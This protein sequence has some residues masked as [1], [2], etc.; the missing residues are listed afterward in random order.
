RSA[1]K[2]I[3]WARRAAN[4]DQSNLSK[5]LVVES[6]AQLSAGDPH[7]AELT[8]KRAANIA[9]NAGE[10]GLV[11]SA[12]A[13]LA[14]CQDHMGDRRSALTYAESALQLLPDTSDLIALRDHF[15]ISELSD[16]EQLKRY[17]ELAEDRSVHEQGRALYLGMA[18]RAAV[19]MQRLSEAVN[20]A[21]QALETDRRIFD[22]HNI[23]VARDLN[24][25]GTALVDAGRLDEAEPH[26]REA[27][28]I[29][30]SEIPDHVLS[31]QPRTHLSRLLT[32]RA[33]KSE[34]KPAPDLVLLE[35]A[36]TIVEPA[37]ARQREVAPNT[38]EYSS[39]LVALADSLAPSNGKRAIEL[40]EQAVEVDRATF[41]DSHIET[42]IDALKL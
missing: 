17:R 31:V 3:A 21:T 23:Y 33:W 30:E 38:A 4:D 11:A 2:Q 7:G 40:L 15:A 34:D 9:K 5:V 36:R 25:L 37:V 19:R 39:A 18:S 35:E 42:S 41:G 1:L 6:N 24:D 32:A 12:Y 29:Y 26:L 13:T 27:I 22:D 28:E 14:W 8:A 10:N 20:L 16:S